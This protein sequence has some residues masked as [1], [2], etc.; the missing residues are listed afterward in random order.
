M[1]DRTV[2]SGGGGDGAGVTGKNAAKPVTAGQDCVSQRNIYNIFV[3]CRNVHYQHLFR[4][5]GWLSPFCEIQNRPSPPQ[6]S[7]LLTL[8]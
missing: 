3:V 5:L 1:Y 8:K 7:R 4:H 2:I 6:D